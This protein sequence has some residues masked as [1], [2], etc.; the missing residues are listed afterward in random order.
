M[1]TGIGTLFILG[2]SYS[3]FEG[4]IPQ[5]YAAYYKKSGP[6][7]LEKQGEDFDPKTDVLTVE[8]TWWHQFIRETDSDL[9]LN[10]SW[11]GTTV[12]NTGYDGIDA[13]AKSFIG[14]LDKLI[15]QGYFRDNRVD[16]LILFGGTNDSWAKSPLGEMMFADWKKEDLYCVLPAVCYLLHRLVENLPDT[17][18]LCVINTKLRPEIEGCFVTACEHYGVDFVM[19]E[20]IEKK[21]G[22]PTILG[23][24]QIKEQILDHLTCDPKGEVQAL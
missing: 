15:E 9:L 17:R 3:T 6:Y 7:Y 14:R 18:L 4:C 5:G 19:L 11:S 22:H 10:C 8:Q 23:M 20:D 21:S 1:V 16:T 2:D 24:E 13:T 12:C